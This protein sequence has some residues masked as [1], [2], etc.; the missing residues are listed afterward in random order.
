MAKPPP[1]VPEGKVGER[2]RSRANHLRTGTIIDVSTRL[3]AKVKWDDGHEAPKIC[4]LYE[5]V[6]LPVD[7]G[8]KPGV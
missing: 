6:K 1:N 4:H 7:T 8:T 2:V 5:L 3:W